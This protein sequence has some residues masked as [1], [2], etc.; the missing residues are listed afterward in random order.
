[1]EAHGGLVLHL[2][3]TNSLDI[4]C[5]AGHGE[6]RVELHCTSRIRGLGMGA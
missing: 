2:R 3:L 5:I 6:Q 4:L 1:M